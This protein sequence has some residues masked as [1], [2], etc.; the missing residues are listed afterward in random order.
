MNQK[1][2]KGLSVFL[3]LFL[4]SCGAKNDQEKS[5]TNQQVELLGAGATFPY[6]LYSKMF[7][8]YQK[9]YQVRV[10]YQSIGSG[11]GVRQIQNKTVD[12]GASDAF[13]SDQK[14]A[15]LPAEVSHIPICLGAVILTYVLPNNPKIKLTPS[16]VAEI[17][18]GKIKYWDD[19]KIKQ[20]NKAESLPHLP[21][22][23]VYRSDGS[24]TTAIFT[25][26]LSKVSQKW[27]KRVGNGKSVNWPIGIG[28]KGNAG[29]SGMIKQT[30]GAMGYVNLAYANQNKLSVAAIQNRSGHF[31]MPTIE[32]TTDAANVSIPNDTRVSITNTNVKTGYPISGFTWI[33]VYNEQNYNNRAKEK[34]VETKK[35]LNWMITKGQLFAK[36]LDY[37]PLPENV[38]KKAK[39]IINNLKFNN[40]KIN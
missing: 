37:S 4:V 28:A 36:P 29:V 35:L 3:V 14:L 10:N 25:D 26:Y 15:K 39:N 9:E 33:L 16:L 11:G 32:S 17:F 1:L 13:L 8:V 20:V 24:G 34:A 18:L 23:I 31:I 30:P 5:E 40:Q 21:I 7:D 19:P 38:V 22:T 12:F 2:I 6:P 27:K